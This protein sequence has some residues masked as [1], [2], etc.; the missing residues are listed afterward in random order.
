MVA[1]EISRQTFLRG[2]AG[3]WSV[4]AFAGAGPANGD[5]VAAG[6]DGLSS[7]IAGQVIQPNAPQFGS[8]KAVFNT[9]YNGLTPAAVVTA[10]SPAD[11]QKAMAFAA[12]N[13]LKV[14]P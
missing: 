1:R 11:V 14:A 13:N 12:A 7:A 4:G 10:T 6:W 8:A 2:A 5:P 3:A 9:N